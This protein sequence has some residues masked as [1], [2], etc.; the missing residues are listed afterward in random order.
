MKIAPDT[1]TKVNYV[2]RS[3]QQADFDTLEKAIK[4]AIKELQ[5]HRLPEPNKEELTQLIQAIVLMSSEK[6]INLSLLYGLGLINLA[7]SRLQPEP[8]LTQTSPFRFQIDLDE[9]SK[10][11]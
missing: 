9:P 5:G 8:D 2:K 11:G 4:W 1:T 6:S 10:Q 3:I 7:K